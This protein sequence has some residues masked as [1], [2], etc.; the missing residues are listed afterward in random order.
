M[1]TIEGETILLHRTLTPF[2][3]LNQAFINKNGDIGFPVRAIC[4]LYGPTGVGKSTIVYAISGYIASEL[5]GSIS[6]ADLEIFDPVFVNTVLDNAGYSGI[7][8]VEPGDT[9]EKILD[10]QIKSLRSESFVVGILDSLAAIS[11]IAEVKGK[12][13]DAIWGRRA[14]I[15]AQ[16]ARKVINAFRQ[17]EVPSIL[18]I[19]NHV[20][21]NMGTL[22]KGT[23][24]AGGKTKE[25]LA[26]TR[27]RIYKSKD[28]DDGSVLL[29]GKV[30]K[31]RFGYSK[32]QFQ[33]FNLAGWGIHPGLTAVMDCVLAGVAIED[34]TIRLGDTK[35]GYFSKMIEQANDAEMFQP[36]VEALNEQTNGR[37]PDRAEDSEE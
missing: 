31:N 10:A 4:E 8:R 28:Y 37:L 19:T 36:F 25:Y 3:S 7:L 16:H 32:R 2:W 35:Y 20:H 15:A 23:H 14:M 12:A 24:T 6:L 17:K 5:N 27:I 13:G 9:D 34:R 30:E 21:Q 1:I 22:A 33:L 29:K 11:P 26:T 18:F